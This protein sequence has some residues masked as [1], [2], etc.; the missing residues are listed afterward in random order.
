[1]VD[2]RINDTDQPGVRLSEGPISVHTCVAIE[3]T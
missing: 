2:D 1:M 3:S